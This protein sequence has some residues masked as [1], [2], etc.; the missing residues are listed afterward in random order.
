VPEPAGKH[1]IAGSGTRGCLY[2]NVTVHDTFDEAV[3]ALVELFN[4]GRTRRAHLKRD[5]ILEF[6][7]TLVESRANADDFGAE[8]CEIVECDCSNRAIHGE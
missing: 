8:Y 3:A 6:K 4:L 2:D 5:R 1:F 7:H